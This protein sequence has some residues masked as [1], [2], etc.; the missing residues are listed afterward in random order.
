MHQETVFCLQK[1]RMMKS[2]GKHLVKNMKKS[3]KVELAL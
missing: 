3:K 2:D 1:K